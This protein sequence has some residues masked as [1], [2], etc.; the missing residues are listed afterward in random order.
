MLTSSFLFKRI[1]FI[2]L[3]REQKPLRAKTLCIFENSFVK[4]RKGLYYRFCNNLAFSISFSQLVNVSDPEV[5]LVEFSYLKLSR[6]LGSSGL[7]FCMRIFWSA[8]SSNIW[9]VKYS[10]QAILCSNYLNKI[11]CFRKI[12]QSHLMGIYILFA[13]KICFSPGSIFYYLVL[14]LTSKMGPLARESAHV[15]MIFEISTLEIYKKDVLYE[16]PQRL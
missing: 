6:K 14:I 4:S 1:F 3:I 5:Q 11:L 12:F 9:S 8:F 13:R 7:F 16:F 10:T 15:T 2:V